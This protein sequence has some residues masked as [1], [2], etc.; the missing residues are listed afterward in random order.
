MSSVIPGSVFLLIGKPV[1]QLFHRCRVKP[2]MTTIFKAIAVMYFSTLQPVTQCV[3]SHA[4]HHA[5][6]A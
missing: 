4:Q 5:G 2:G 1:F 3:I 6:P